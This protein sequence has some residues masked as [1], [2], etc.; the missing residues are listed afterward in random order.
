MV[1]TIIAARLELGLL[2]DASHRIAYQLEV[3]GW[4][5]MKPIIYRFFAT[6]TP[7]E[8]GA[9]VQWHRMSRRLEH[10]T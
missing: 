1:T 6:S 2:L 7:K 3:V 10:T 4:D 9:G 5:G 8:V